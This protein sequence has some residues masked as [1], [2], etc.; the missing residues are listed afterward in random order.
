MRFRLCNEIRAW[1]SN[2]ADTHTSRGAANDVEGG[3]NASLAL[4]LPPSM[5]DAISVAT[6]SSPGSDTMLPTRKRPRARYAVAGHSR[7]LK[8]IID[9]LNDLDN[10]SLIWAE[11]RKRVQA[12]ELAFEIAKS[13]LQDAA[14]LAQLDALLMRSREALCAQA[15]LFATHRQ[16]CVGALSLR[17]QPV[18]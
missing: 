14:H 4:R 10:D 7:K 13:D 15:E 9:N 3:R 8:P 16:L 5:D 12:M 6:V 2:L 18:E 11:V 1:S 17:A